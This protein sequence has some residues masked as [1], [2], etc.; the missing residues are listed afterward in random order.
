LMAS[1]ASLCS[2]PSD[3]MLTSAFEAFSHSLLVE[4]SSSTTCQWQF[5][6]DANLERHLRAASLAGPLHAS[7]GSCSLARTRQV[8]A[9]KSSA[10]GEECI[11]KL[12]Q[13]GSVC[14]RGSMQ[15]EERSLL[16]MPF[17]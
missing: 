17:Q 13:A 5:C 4:A 11:H 15:S 7:R 6:V 14:H 9:T 8:Y 2:I 10:P 3:N 12:E 1:M 16:D